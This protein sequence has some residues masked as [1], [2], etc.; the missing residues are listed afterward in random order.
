VDANVIKDKVEIVWQE[1]SAHWKDEFAAR[2]RVA[3][4]SELENTLGRINNTSAQLNEAID[5][6]LSS[7]LEFND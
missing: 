3:V 2:Y 4:I 7:L 1:T 5:N 6:A